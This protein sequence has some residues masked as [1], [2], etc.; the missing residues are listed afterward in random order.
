VGE[1]IS[2]RTAQ[3]DLRDLVARGVLKKTG[4]GPASRYLVSSSGSAR[5]A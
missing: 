3:Y 5:F 1:A 2:V 4:K